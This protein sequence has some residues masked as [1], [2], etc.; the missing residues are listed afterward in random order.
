MPLFIP[1]IGEID[2]STLPDLSIGAAV[3]PASPEESL[4]QPASN[5]NHVRLAI[6]FQNFDEAARNVLVFF[7]GAGPRAGSRRVPHC[8]RATLRLDVGGIIMRD[9]VA[10]VTGAN[11]ELACGFILASGYRHKNQKA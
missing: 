2:G 5:R 7:A 9:A 3:N 10:L 8:P 1:S 4:Q 6:S 11:R